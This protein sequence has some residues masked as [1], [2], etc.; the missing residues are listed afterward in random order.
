MQQMFDQPFAVQW[1][2]HVP[3]GLTFKNSV[4]C[5]HSVFMCSV[6]ISEQTAIISQYIMN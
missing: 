5:P 1:L 6:W 4:F 2:L 3:P